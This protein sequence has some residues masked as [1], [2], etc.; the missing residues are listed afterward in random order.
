MRVFRSLVVVPNVCVRVAELLAVMERCAVSVGLVSHVFDGD[1]NSVSE[2]V[3]FRGQVIE[4]CS[5]VLLGLGVRDGLS[6]SPVG[7][8]ILVRDKLGEDVV[9]GASEKDGVHVLGLRVTVS[10]GSVGVTTGVG[11]LSDSVAV[12]VA[13]AVEVLSTVP[14]TV[15]VALP[16]EST[17][18]VKPR[19]AGPL[20]L[21]SV[22]LADA[23]GDGV[24]PDGVNVF[25]LLEALPVAV[26]VSESD[27]VKLYVGVG[28]GEMRDG[29]VD[30]DG[31]R[32]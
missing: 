17:V 5:E 21:E 6:V 8:G 3:M 9:L 4:P 2:I 19:V 15:S 23:D 32:E 24:S 11:R 30:S 29:D 18:S 28:D 16:V 25:V 31:V 26:G 13:V 22:A 7:V 10:V 1:G 27:G 12:I 14:V 20:V